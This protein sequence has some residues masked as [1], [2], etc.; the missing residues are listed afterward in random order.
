MDNTEQEKLKD[1]LK[2]IQLDQYYRQINGKL[3]IT[4]LSHFD[5]VTEEDLDDL[6]MAKPEQ[7][8]LFEALKKAKKKSLF[9]SFRRKKSKKA[10]AQADTTAERTSCYG[11]AGDSLTCLISEQSL[12]LYEM[13]GNGAFGYVRRGKWSKNS[14]KKVHVAVKCL[15]AWNDKAFQQM[16][17]E[18]IKEA[19]A[20]SLLDHPHIIRLH[21][22]VLSTPMMLVTELAPLGCLLARLRDEPHNFTISGLSDF[23]VQ[24]AS[25]MAYLE[26]HRFVHRDLA[27]RNLLLESYEKVKI[28]DFGMMRVLSE[29]DD[30]YTMQPSGKV[31][32]A[33]CPQE[34]L[35]FR[36]FSHAS[37][38]WAFGIT[39]LELF[40]YGM[41][42]WPGLNGAEI[43]EKVDMPLCERPKRPDHCPTEIYNILLT[44]CWSHE[45]HQRARFSMLKKMVDEAHP[46]NGAAVF[47]YESK[48]QQNLSFQEGDIIT[49][50]EASPDV[51]W[52]KGQNMRTKHVGM[53]PSELVES[54]LRRAIS[55]VSHRT[56]PKPR[57]PIKQ[58]SKQCNQLP[59]C[60]CGSAHI[61]ETPVLL[62]SPDLFSTSN[63]GST[64]F[65]SRSVESDLTSSTEVDSGYSSSI[66]IRR[67]TLSNSEN[68]PEQP[69]ANFGALYENTTFRKQDTKAAAY[70]LMSPPTGTVSSPIPIPKQGTGETRFP[71][72]QRGLLS[73]P[74][75][76][77]RK[78]PL[79]FCTFYAP[80]L[81]GSNTTSPPPLPAKM[82]SSLPISSVTQSQ[83]NPPRLSK[84]VSPPAGKKSP[85]DSGIGETFAQEML[86]FLKGASVDKSSD[87]S[88]GKQEEEDIYEDLSRPF[89]AVPAN[90]SE[91]RITTSS[92]KEPLKAR[93]AHSYEN[94]S[95]PVKEQST[96]KR[97]HQKDQNGHH[98]VSNHQNDRI[99][100]H[101]AYQL[102]NDYQ[103]R[104]A[105][106]NTW[107]T[108]QNYDNHKLKDADTASLSGSR[109]YDNH[110]LRPADSNLPPSDAFYDN[111]KIKGNSTGGS[112][113]QNKSFYENTEL[114]MGKTV[115]HKE[116]LLRET[117]T[118]KPEKEISLN[119]AQSVEQ[120]YENCVLKSVK[121]SY[122]NCTPQALKN[123]GHEHD[124][125]LVNDSLYENCDILDKKKETSEGGT[126][127]M[128]IPRFKAQSD[129]NPLEFRHSLPTN[130]HC[131]GVVPDKPHGLMS[132]VLEKRN[133]PALTR[134]GSADAINVN[135]DKDDAVNLRLPD[136]NLDIQDHPVPPPRWKRIARTQSLV[137]CSKQRWEMT[138][139]P[140][141]AAALSKRSNITVLGEPTATN[142]DSN[143]ASDPNIEALSDKKPALPPR[144]NKNSEITP[145]PLNTRC[146]AY[147]NVTLPNK[148]SDKEPCPPELPPK[149]QRSNGN[150]IFK[151]SSLRTRA[152]HYENVEGVNGFHVI[153]NQNVDLQQESDSPPPLPRKLSQTKV[154]PLIPCRVD[155]K[156]KC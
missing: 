110:K 97:E 116:E 87:D 68:S 90:P 145:A 139:S 79:D 36:K 148:L 120:S 1:L 27:A 131:V 2:D 121:T 34:V 76:G 156:Q 101:S 23:V 83:D 58:R 19:N 12:T 52:W 114:Q 150:N 72:E 112:R 78:C 18:F 80:Q 118:R 153:G 26:S 103:L 119:K 88:S 24:I 13:L 28:G 22:I 127:G 129:N 73:T 62:Y 44:H 115:A 70:E 54:G 109:C 45:P 105:R 3:H 134:A 56:P 59:N 133:P 30:H 65:S 141:L 5:H 6:G 124:Q 17:M 91:G 7:R 108:Q 29:E 125:K 143:L 106:C 9:S 100:C 142:Q 67:F 74:P 46:V 33:W 123:G 138:M 95:I 151:N 155:L 11:V 42:P 41:E 154:P 140:E 75:S 86:T 147:E 55:P 93:N 35:K 152:F 61:Y 126:L 113:E 94:H 81:S 40:S 111:W 63:S 20:M 16:Q 99:R 96:K 149:L 132:I 117:G 122:E 15:K 10:D 60:D 64:S 48:C 38:V 137:G 31:P 130:C 32:F 128:T 89:V 4:R 21:G 50:L 51:S 53:F 69:K 146:N 135:A 47:P 136:D 49:L 102:E 104:D 25:G 92:T 8:R 57:S 77:E 71:R 98:D 43:L 85:L 14:H 66:D 82:S 84:T 144:A 37:D 107:P 39:V